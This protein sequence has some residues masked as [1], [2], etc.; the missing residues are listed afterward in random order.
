[1]DEHYIKDQIADD[2]PEALFLDGMDGDKNAFNDA[3]IGIAERCGMNTIAAYDADI[4]I[5][6]LFKKYDMSMEEAIEWYDFNIAGAYLGENTPIYIND[7]R[8][9]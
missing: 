2:N 3:L 9:Y 7:L 6:I 8:E 5:D 4:I 1:M